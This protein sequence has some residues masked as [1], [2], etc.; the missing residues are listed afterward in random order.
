VTP[1]ANH[2]MTKITHYLGVLQDEGN[3]NIGTNV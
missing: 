2:S 3:T 1:L